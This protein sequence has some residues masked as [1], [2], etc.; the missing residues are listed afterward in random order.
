MVSEE[1]L[2]QAP[3]ALFAVQ[4]VDRDGGGVAEVA[5]LWVSACACVC[6]CERRGA[7]VRAHSERSRAE[8]RGDMADR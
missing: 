7:G 4:Q 8:R 5:A 2:L 1:V 6:V 3:V